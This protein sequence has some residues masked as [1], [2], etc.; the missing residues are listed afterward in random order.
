MH[1]PSDSDAS[2]DVTGT[3]GGRLSS[4]MKLKRSVETQQQPSAQTAEH[5][6]CHPVSPLQSPVIRSPGVS[7]QHQKS[8]ATDKP[9]SQS[10][11]GRPS[12]WSRRTLSNEPLGVEF[13]V[14]QISVRRP[15][16]AGT[17]P[18]GDFDFFADMTPVITSSVP[19][20]S[21]LSVLS[22]TAAEAS[23][24]QPSSRLNINDV[25]H[26]DSAVSVV[27]WIVV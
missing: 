14:K 4:A 11:A 8:P 13:D 27:S 12:A 7:T 24:A 16:D 9:S 3:G 10:S 23:S 2:T 19:P 5:D 25:N 26:L 21:L 17:S 6:D 20:Q 22:A 1:R 15:T 18:R